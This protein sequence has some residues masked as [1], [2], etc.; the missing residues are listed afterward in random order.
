MK[1]FRIKHNLTQR[2]LADLIGV[3]RSALS[4]WELKNRKPK[5]IHRLKIIWFFI[6][7][8]LHLIELDNK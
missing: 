7:Y 1:K 3:S 8:Y 5:V 6:K 4:H 2:Q